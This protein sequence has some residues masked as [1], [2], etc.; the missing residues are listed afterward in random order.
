[1][2]LNYTLD[3]GYGAA[4]LGLIVLTTDETLE[5]EARGCVAGRAVSLLHA[6]IPAQP[7][8]TPEALATMEGHM[9][10]VAGSLPAGLDVVGYGCTSGATVIGPAQVEALI[11]RA[12]P[13][14]AVTNPLSAVIAALDVLGARRIG[15]LTPYV[16]SVNAPLVAALGQAGIEVVTRAS[17]EQSDD[18]S[19]ARIPESD[20]LRGMETLVETGGCEAI[21]ASCTNLRAFGIVDEAEARLGIP[22]ISSNLALVWHML[23][24]AGLEAKGWGPGRLFQL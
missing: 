3:N 9:E 17:F 8:V 16:D 6:R 24:L 10:A 5:N 22:V 15:L 14:A 19:V 4:R 1:M 12:Q 18:W 23:R 7:H 21:F 20:T 13:G 11:R 2:G